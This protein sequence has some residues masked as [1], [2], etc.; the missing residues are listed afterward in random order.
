MSSVRLIPAP[1][2]IVDEIELIA[3]GEV[4][5][6]SLV[7]RAITG[8]NSGHAVLLEIFHLPEGVTMVCGVGEASNA[9][10][11]YFLGHV[12]PE[13][14]LGEYIADMRWSDEHSGE[15]PSANLDLSDTAWRQYVRD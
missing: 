13:T 5:P 9:D 8:F 4:K 2:K 3:L 14:V 10:P 1:P 12:V 6:E 11:W 7:A 15:D